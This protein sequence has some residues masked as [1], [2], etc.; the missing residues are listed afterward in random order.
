[1][2]Q[3]I[4]T[5][6]GFIQIPLLAIVIASIVVAL[7]GTGVVL[8]RQGKLASIVANISEVFKG[9]GD[10]TISEEKEVKSEE[11]Q[12]DQEPE[13]IG[14]EVIQ[15]E[16]SQKEISQQELEKA[17]LEAEKAKQE[18]EKTK[19]EMEKLKAEQESEKAKAEAERLKAEQ[20][21]QKQQQAVLKI[22]MCKSK[23][24]QNKSER[25]THFEVFELPELRQVAQMVAQVGYQ[26]CVEK[27]RQDS[28]VDP[29]S[30]SGKTYAEI[31]SG[32][33]QICGSR[34]SSEV[35]L[36]PLKK[37]SLDKIEQQLQQEYQECLNE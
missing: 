3:K 22:E 24:A 2:S 33:T 36:A 6:K 31:S 10:T 14:E 15:Q 20:E 19:A 4:K 13:L 27:C 16:V 9:V 21:L 17:K 23:Y 30:I 32:C 12:I 18:A 34:S 1:M 37:Q 8:H 5:Q 35:F 28:G 7:A 29:S 26:K 11:S 25:I